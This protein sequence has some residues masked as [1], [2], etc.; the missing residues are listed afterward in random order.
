MQAL[1]R[2][3]AL[4]LIALVPC[5]AAV[6]QTPAIKPGLWEYR[7]VT[8][9]R[10]GELEA[11]MAEARKQMA[12][13]PPEQRRQMERMMGER[14]LQLGTSP[15]SANVIRVCVGPDEAARLDMQ[16]DPRCKQEI[17]QRTRDTVKV[18]FSCS[19]E[20]PSRG[21]GTVRFKGDTG[22]TGTFWVETQVAGKPDRMDV[23]QEGTWLGADCGKL[24]PRR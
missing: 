9:S 24:K 5:S 2:R 12:A 22:F 20:T 4:S 17:V 23:T 19:G 11:A 18:V 14:G 7:F 3:I 16:S 10:S 15:G 8:K 21:E 13:I 1:S 6:A